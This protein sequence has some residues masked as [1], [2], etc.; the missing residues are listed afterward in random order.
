MTAD[1]KPFDTGSADLAD[2]M[3]VERFY[4][5]ELTGRERAIKL[6]KQSLA[7]LAR[8]VGLALLLVPFQLMGVVTLD[9]PLSMFDR[10][11]PED[12][13]AA[14]RFMSQG[15][16]Y[17]M[18]V[19]LA[20]L[21]MTRR[22]GSQLTG[23]V[24]MLSWVLTI[25]FLTMLIVDLAPELDSEDFPSARFV[26][27]LIGSW[28][29]GQLVAVTVYDLLR[30][31]AWWRA[32]FFG[33]ALGFAVQAAI[34]FPG[35]FAGTGAPWGWWMAVSL[36]LTTLISAVFLLFYGPLRR[37]IRPVPGLGG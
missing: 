1:H 25:V 11:T 7:A 8:L 10:L 22:W 20:V 36:F 31:G 2:T 27:S 34:Y 3:V 17:L 33:S 13:L 19:L 26:G 37:L 9:L 24:I 30:G 18:M 21:L 15:E 32:P 14:S 5:R 4:D 23:R 16:G 28:F 35:A 12:G 29:V 6:L